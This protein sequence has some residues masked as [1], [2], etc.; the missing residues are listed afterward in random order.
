M[1]QSVTRRGV[2]ATLGAAAAMRS[3][4]AAEPIRIGFAEA[5]TGGLAV[6]GKSGVLAMQIWADEV[7]AKGGLLG[8][9]VKLVFYDSQSNPANIPGIYV[10]LLDVDHVDL[11]ISGYA[12]NMA[13][14]AMPIVMAHNKLFVS[15]FCLAVNTQFHYPRY[16]AMLP[17]GPDPKHAFSD[18]FFDLTKTLTPR[19]QTVAIVAA[20]AEF[21][22]NASDGARDNAKA[23]GLRI[24]YDRSYPPT[25]ADYTPIVRAVRATNPDV[26][27]VASYPPDTAGILRAA[28]EIGLRAQLF[29]GG[30]V[31]VATSA[32]K[33]QLG[34]LLNGVV[35]QQN[36]V[37]APTLQ[38]PG[39]MDFLKRYQAQAASAGVDPLGYFLPPWAYGRMQMLQQA[40]EATGGIDDDKLAD[41]FRS[42]TFKTVIGDVAFSPGGEWA[43]PRMIVTQFQGIEGHDLA[44]FR[45]PNIE[46]VL[47]PSEFK[48]GTLVSPYG[49]QK[50]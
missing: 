41:Y 32:L 2:I 10:K 5:L 6:V 49:A 11:V 9:P 29:G 28:S 43:K 7:N 18:E 34:P 37:P 15:L 19:P 20:D 45:N 16:F 48:S 42:H 17:T 23:A 21:A 31:G 46:V 39:V 35:V 47:L 1:P 8:R 14:P 26:I 24:V 44:Q 22:R 27:Y 3:A 36:W 38:F 13:A 50:S 30:M 4:R 25:T 12:T 33:T 40:I